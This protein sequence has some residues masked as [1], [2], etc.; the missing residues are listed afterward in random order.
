MN[1]TYPLHSSICK[2]KVNLAKRKSY[3]ERACECTS[4]LTYKIVALYWGLAVLKQVGW[5]PWELGIGG[6]TS[7]KELMVDT[8]LK[9]FPFKAPPK[10]VVE[11]GM[12]TAGYNL[13]ELVRH[14]FFA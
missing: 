8:A 14:I 6:T 10:V 2:E 12:F 5:L 9:E 3:I 1:V 7:I 11:Y 13:S 4:K